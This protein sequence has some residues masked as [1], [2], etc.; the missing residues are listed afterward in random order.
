MDKELKQMTDD[1]D[2]IMNLFKKMEKSS[3]DDVDTLKEESKLLH[4]ELKERYGEENTPETDSQE[5]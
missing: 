4:K 3:L 2:R 1:L 5:A